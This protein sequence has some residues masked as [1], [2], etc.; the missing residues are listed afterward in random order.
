MYKMNEEDPMFKRQ[1]SKAFKMKEHEMDLPYMMISTMDKVLHG[2][3]FVEDTYFL[4]NQLKTF[5]KVEY[6]FLMQLDF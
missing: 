2:V 4:E 1:L 6:C 3:N 5:M